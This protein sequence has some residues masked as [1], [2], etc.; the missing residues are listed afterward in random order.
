MV[1]AHMNE[2][3]HLSAMAT[4]Q[5]LS[6]YCCWFRMEEHVTEFVKQC[7]HRMD[8]KAG[9]KAPR[10]LGETVHSTRTGE[11]VHFGYL[12]VGASGPMGDDGL[13]EDGVSR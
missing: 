1:C 8:S 4:L 6:E 5:R 13:D 11:V 2:A 9:E 12:Y 7:L 10:P 3:G